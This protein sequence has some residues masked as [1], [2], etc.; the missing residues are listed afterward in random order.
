MAEDVAEHES[1]GNRQ[2]AFLQALL[3]R[4]AITLEEAKPLIAAIETANAPERPMLSEDVSQ[5]V[6]EDYIERVNNAVSQ[7]DFEIRSTL[8]QIDRQRVYALVNTTSDALTQMATLHTADEIAYVKRVLDAIFETYNTRRAEVMAITS[9]QA[10]EVAKLPSDRRESIAQTQGTQ[11]SQAAGLTKSQAQNVLASL[12]AQGWFELSPRGYYTLSPRALMEL[13]DWLFRTYNDSAQD[14]DDEDQETAPRIKN[15][16]ACRDIVT[17]GQRCPDLSC[18]ARLHNDC[19]GKIFRAQHGQQ[20]CPRCKIEWKDAPP[21]GEKAARA[22]AST[23]R[24]SDV[25]RSSAGGSRGVHDDEVEND[26]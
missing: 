15:C 5:D 6:L 12:V 20:K 26:G 21:V 14:S 22:S 16:D 10:L 7:Y 19:V 25:R 2:R 18:N 17:V 3:A 9:M 24:S 11:A 1:Y 13:R 8:H 4:Q 23:A